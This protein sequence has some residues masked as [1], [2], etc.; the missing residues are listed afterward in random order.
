MCANRIITFVHTGRR[1]DVLLLIAGTLNATFKTAEIQL[2]GC[3]TV[4][5][6]NCI[7]F[8]GLV[9]GRYLDGQNRVRA[10]VRVSIMTVQIKTAR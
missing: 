10:R 5:S 7:L 6:P 3:S 2:K 4:L 9:S 1:Y 8:L